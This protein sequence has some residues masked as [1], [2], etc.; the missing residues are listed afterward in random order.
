[1]NALPATLNH[2]M[3]SSQAK[4]IL[5]KEK[6]EVISQVEQKIMLIN[7]I[8][9]GSA[10]L[11]VELIT[12]LSEMESQLKA[13]MAK[14][15]S[16][17]TS[18]CIAEAYR[19]FLEVSNNVDKSLND[20]IF[21]IV[22]DYN[23][24]VTGIRKL[25]V[26]AEEIQIP[27][28]LRLTEQDVNTVIRILNTID[29][30]VYLTTSRINQIVEGLEKTLGGKYT[31]L[32][33][34]DFK[35]LEKVSEVVGNETMR[36]SAE[37]CLAM[38]ADAVRELKMNPF[39]DEKIAL[40]RKLNQ[41]IIETF[42]MDKLSQIVS[43][44]NENVNLLKKY[45]EYLSSRK[46]ELR[47]IGL[48]ES[49][50]YAKVIEDLTFT[51]NGNLPTCEIVRR[52]YSFISVINDI[53]E[54]VADFQSV[55]ALFQLLEGLRDVIVAKVTEE[56]C[57]SLDEVGIDAKYGRFVVSWLKGIGITA[58]LKENSVCGER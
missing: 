1:M 13:E 30:N 24:V 57:I 43:L 47:K 52:V 16:C 20:A 19:N 58:I 10:N 33:V 12:V 22:I 4:S 26:N 39:S 18:E 28:S 41:V 32:L 27:P 5:Q 56:G 51:V 54:I 7:N 55:S 15:N 36:R 38:Q 3:S 11:P 53:D 48:P 21:K 31:R 50:E 8:K 35:S 49:K 40:S 37:E 17:S 44:S 14:M 2:L 23:N 6:N 9:G 25:G 42:S 34:T 46:D 29:R 45:F